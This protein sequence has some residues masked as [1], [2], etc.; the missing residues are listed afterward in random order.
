MCLNFKLAGLLL[1]FCG[2]SAGS[3]SI[4]SACECTEISH[5]CSLLYIRILFGG[6]RRVIRQ[7]K[8]WRAKPCNARCWASPDRSESELQDKL[9]LEDTSGI[10]E[11]RRR[12]RHG[13]SGHGP[14]CPK[15]N[16]QECLQTSSRVWFCWSNWTTN[17]FTTS[18]TTSFDQLVRHPVTNSQWCSAK[19]EN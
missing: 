10:A 9:N 5:I 14:Y 8:P 18:R 7:S 6:S 1:A 15:T 13:S 3:A 19:Y 12:S 4:P 16:F 11:D 2:P 17:Q